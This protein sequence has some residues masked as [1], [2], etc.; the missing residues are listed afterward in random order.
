M[1][2]RETADTVAGSRRVVDYYEQCLPDYRRFWGTEKNLS[3]HY[4]FFDEQHRRH[5]DALVNM[6]RVLARMARIGPGDR[7]LDAGCGIGG[8]T[9]WLAVELGADVTGINI[10]RTQVEKARTL[11]RRNNIEN[12]ARFVL[13]DFSDTA[14]SDGS[15]DVVW[16]LESACYAEDKKKFLREA[17]RILRPGGRIVIADGFIKKDNLSDREKTDMERW[18]GGW[19][20]PNLSDVEGFRRDLE[21]VG[22]RNIHYSDITRNVTPSSKRMFATGVVTF[23]GGKALELAGVRTKIQTGHMI[24]IFYQHITLRKGLWV[25]SIFYAEK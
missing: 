2:L 3:I 23:P 12:R 19:A 6:N 25:Y 15:F 18:L 16:G 7:V 1:S 20:V 8:S 13:G 14:F 17:K 4:G 11:A 22:F 10:H 24:A 9:I 21:E 5:G